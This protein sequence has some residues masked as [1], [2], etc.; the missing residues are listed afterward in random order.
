MSTKRK[1]ALTPDEY[2][3]V[4]DYC[5][6]P[7]TT[8]EQACKRFLPDVTKYKG[9]V[10][11]KICIQLYYA[12]NIKEY[13][14]TT[15]SVFKWLSFFNPEVSLGSLEGKHSE[16]TR[17][18]NEF[19]EQETDDAFEIAK[20]AETHR[21]GSEY[22]ETAIESLTN[23]VECSQATNQV[24][25][26]LKCNPSEY[27]EADIEEVCKWFDLDVEEM[28]SIWKKGSAEEEAEMKATEEKKKQEAKLKKRAQQKRA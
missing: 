11:V 9:R 3:E 23:Y 4:Y 1:L 28:T 26:E 6:K 18:W 12:A 27:D 21:I 5:R 10:L 14:L 17:H 2:K 15:S 22:D 24:Q 20:I 16:V 8:F 7:S 19:A 13:C 25:D